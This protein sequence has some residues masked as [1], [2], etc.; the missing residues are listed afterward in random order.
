MGSKYNSFNR[1]LNENLKINKDYGRI[2]FPII[3]IHILVG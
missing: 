3:M 1:V 2:F